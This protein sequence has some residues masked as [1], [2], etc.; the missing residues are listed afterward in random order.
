MVDDIRVQLLAKA[1]RLKHHELSKDNDIST[2]GYFKALAEEIIKTLD[3]YYGSARY[4]MSAE[5]ER[6]R[7]LRELQATIDRIRNADVSP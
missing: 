5:F 4:W 7:V 1:M 3:E 6:D 2:A